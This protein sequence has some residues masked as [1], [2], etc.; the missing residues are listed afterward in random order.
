M[1]VVGTQ[2]YTHI[3]RRLHRLWHKPIRLLSGQHMTF[4][5]F[6]RRLHLYLAFTCGGN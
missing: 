1:D 4:N 5:H 6:N 3:E 2:G